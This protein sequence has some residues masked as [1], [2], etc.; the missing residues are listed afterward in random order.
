M[1]FDHSHNDG[2][3]EHFLIT[4][5]NSYKGSSYFYSMLGLSKFLHVITLSYKKREDIW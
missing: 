4:T 2:P 1:H 3:L 5:N